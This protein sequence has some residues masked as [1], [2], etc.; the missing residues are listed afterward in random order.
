MTVK[1]V[2]APVNAA[3]VVAAGTANIAKIR[4]TNVSKSSAPGATPS[5]TPAA[6]SAPSYA[7][8]VPQVRTLTGAAEEERLN[9]PQRVYI[10]Q[11]DIEASQGAA[12]VRVQESTF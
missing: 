7:V 3:T 11:S 10:L 1:A 5:A 6:V 2:L 8:D 9:Q 12:K 4:A